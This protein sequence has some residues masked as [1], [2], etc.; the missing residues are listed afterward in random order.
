MP[1]YNSALAIDVGNGGDGVCAVTLPANTLITLA[2]RNYECTTLDINQ[3][4]NL[5]KGAGGAVVVIKVQ[6][7]V[8]IN[9]NID[10]SGA[11]GAEGDVAA[12]SGGLAGPGGSDGGGSQLAPL[13][14]LEGFGIGKGLPG[15]YV[16]PSNSDSFGGG[17]GGGSYNT[18]SLIEPVDGEDVGGP[19]GLFA[20]GSNGD[21]YGDEATF[22]TLFLGGS[23]GGAGGGGVDSASGGASIRAG[24]SGGGGGGAIHII[25]GGDVII[26]GTII[27]NGGNGGGII[28]TVSSGGGG[29]GSGGSIWIQAVGAISGSG[30]INAFGGLHGINNHF[31]SGGYGGHGSDGRI[32]LDDSDG[33]VTLGSVLPAS[34]GG[35][36]FIPTS[37]SASAISRQY[38]SSIACGRVVLENEKPINNLINLFLGIVIAS[39]IYFSMSRKGK[40]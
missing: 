16:A 20:M 24:S 23:G 40:I 33:L 8:T 5:F 39:M 11:D 10:I 28:T 38:S 26:N 37:N 21:P 3:N 30:T 27:S 13:P 4:L 29:G 19:G 18:K 9:S 36:I 35:S 12:K 15:K 32:R 22:E 34:R 2:Q 25:A 7:I 17:G 6:G 14:G 31:D 1:F